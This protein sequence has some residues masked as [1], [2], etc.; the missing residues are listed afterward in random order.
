MTE[1]VAR[2]SLINS[3]RMLASCEMSQA[4]AASTINSSRIAR[5]HPFRAGSVYVPIPGIDISMIDQVQFT[6]CP[7]EAP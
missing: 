4:S 2:L 7:P 5:P 1:K 6:R 3:A